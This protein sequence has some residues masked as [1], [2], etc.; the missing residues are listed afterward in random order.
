M[1]CYDMLKN[2]RLVEVNLLGERFKV[3][4]K[5]WEVSK[6]STYKQLNGIAEELFVQGIRLIGHLVRLGL[7]TGL[8]PRL[9]LWEV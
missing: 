1:Q 9:Y 8:P 5:E 7:T 2:N 4:L 3:Q 6:R